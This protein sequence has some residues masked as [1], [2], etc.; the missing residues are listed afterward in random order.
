MSGVGHG[1]RG[2]L[3]GS[4]F[5]ELPGLGRR[6]RF[7]NRWDAIPALKQGSEYSKLV[8]WPFTWNVHVAPTSWPAPANGNGRVREPRR[9]TTVIQPP[10]P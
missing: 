5:N 6:G 8:A 9:C 3:A 7:F 1:G 2:S 4:N 10:P